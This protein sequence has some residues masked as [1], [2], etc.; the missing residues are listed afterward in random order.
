MLASYDSGGHHKDQ[1]KYEENYGKI[2]DSK[3]PC[4]ECDNTRAQGHA[5]SCS[6]NWRNKNDS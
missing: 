6:K 4:P 1:E 3:W 2:F 5:L